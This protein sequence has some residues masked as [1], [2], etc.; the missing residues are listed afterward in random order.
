M[1]VEGIRTLDLH[2]SSIPACLHDTTQENR[3]IR[4]VAFGKNGRVLL[5][6]R[7]LR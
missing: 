2:R 6:V 4:D 3:D 1:V 7:I 5:D